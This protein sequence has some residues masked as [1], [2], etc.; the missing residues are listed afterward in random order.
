MLQAIRDKTQGIFA[1]CVV[2]I[3]VIVFFLWG[4]STYL[5]S[6]SIDKKNVVATV[7]RSKIY[8]AEYRQV[9][10]NEYKQQVDQSG[11]N[12][13]LVNTDDLKKQVLKSLVQQEV[14]YQSAKNMGMWLT[15]EMVD[16]LIEREPYFLQD[17]VFSQD[18][19]QQ[20]LNQAGMNIESL[21]ENIRKNMLI[22]QMQFSILASSFVLPGE[23]FNFEN[24]DTQQRQFRYFIVNPNDIK[25]DNKAFNNSDISAYYQDNLDKFKTLPEVK[26]KY[27]L[28][29]YDALKHKIKPTASQLGLYYAE[30]LTAEQK[31]DP[32]SKLVEIK[33]KLKQAYIDDHAQ[34]EYQ[35]LGN[36]LQQ[37]TFENPNS[38][39]VAAET[40]NLPIK[41]TGYFSQNQLKFSNKQDE[42][43]LSIESI[44][45]TAFNDDI[46]E[47]KVN[48]D[49]INLSGRRAIVIRRSGY[50]PV[51][52]LPLSEVSNKISKIL[53][54]KAQLKKLNI[55][56]NDL[57]ISS[58]KQAE[59]IMKTHN[60]SWGA[61]IISSRDN[62]KDINPDLL[63]AV[64]NTPIIV[65]AS[66][67]GVIYQ[68]LH[69]AKLNKNIAV[70]QL[71][72]I[73]ADNNKDNNKDKSKDENKE[74]TKKEYTKILPLLFSNMIYQAYSNQALSNAKVVYT[75]SDY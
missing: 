22:N 73:I 36:Q 53:L 72:K 46:L 14:L 20:I 5:T 68:P 64:F 62:N 8:Q 10:Q 65:S 41:E 61:E 17:G 58:P 6:S 27:I 15:K 13:N 32:P 1:W 16:Q 48:S 44:R 4:L 56:L 9:Y 3:L 50:K 35:N 21:R 23:I 28:L 25:L 75:D 57:E 7:N 37:L 47:Q 18:K 42:E 60:W 63:L 30:N 52:E 69:N 45:N 51:A 24:L 12:I 70:F 19:M 55:L 71:Q 40:L 38:L 54:Q 33:Q 59:A 39:E 49:I 66:G 31:K 67:K 11:G 34:K 2:I 29:S 74:K 43:L 26:I